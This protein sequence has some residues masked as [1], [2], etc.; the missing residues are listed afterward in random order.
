MIVSEECYR[1]LKEAGE[2]WKKRQPRTY[3]YY[4]NPLQ[5]IT[6][7]S[8]ENK[9]VSKEDVEAENKMMESYRIQRWGR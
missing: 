6:N 9:F 8:N 3:D 4:G 2:G 7:A 1:R 5:G